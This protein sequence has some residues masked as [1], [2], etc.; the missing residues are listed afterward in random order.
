MSQLYTTYVITHSVT[1]QSALLL[2]AVVRHTVVRALRTI[3]R[4]SDRYS[5]HSTATRIQLKHW[6]RVPWTEYKY[7][8][9]Q[10]LRY[11]ANTYAYAYRRDETPEDIRVGFMPYMY[12]VHVY[13]E[14]CKTQ[15]QRLV[16]YPRLLL[17]LH[18]FH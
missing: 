14:Y 7:F 3:M 5:E 8:E 12:M 1:L 18:G 2:V 17:D 13:S 11:N 16:R 9:Y 15:T 6:Y 10:S 4:C